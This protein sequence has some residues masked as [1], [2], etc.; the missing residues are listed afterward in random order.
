[1]NGPL[2]G[3][4]VVDLTRVVA[5]PYAT[6]LLAD[7]GAEVIKIELP[8]KGDDGRYGYPSV[9]GVPL[10]FAA[11]NRN[12]KGITLDV[13]KEA[14][15]QI[16]VKLVGQAD[17]LVENFAAGTME[18]WGLGYEQ[19]KAHNPRLI[20]AA[21][22]GFG[23]TGPYAKRTSYDIIAQAMGGLMSLTGFAEGPPVRGGGAL[24]DFIGGLFTAFAIVCALRARDQF[25][26]G[27]FVEVSNMDAILSMTDNWLTLAAL[28]GQKPPRLG[29]Q[30]PFTAPYD[31]FQAR[32]GWV[33]IAV[34][35]SALFRTLM[36]AIGRPELGR[37]PRFKTPQSRLENRQ[38]VHAVVQS[39]VSQRTVE[40][41]LD[42]LGPEGANIPCARVM[43]MQDLLSDPHVLAREMVVEVPD[44]VLGTVPVTGIPVKFS[45]TP[46]EIRSLGPRLGQH[47]PEVYGE[48]LGLSEAELEQLR[49]DGVI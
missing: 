21:L 18:K 41:V 6:M 16:L 49:R 32:D 26:I 31:C 15:K 23:Q 28:T 44:A 29:N 10:A 19:L 4:R 3:V 22:S 47:N 9:Q 1:M 38:Q 7:L 43:E 39:W 35:N 8:V 40:E 25:G 5:G 27:Q 48:M 42:V 34:G 17:V 11:L 24:G 36:A 37:D 12:K 46:G 45:E 20:Y 33:V 14:G 13:R 2:H 30:H